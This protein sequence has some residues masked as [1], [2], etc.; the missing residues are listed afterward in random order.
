[1]YSCS[2]DADGAFDAIPRP[3]LFRKAI[4]H[5]EPNCWKLM[6]YWY[7]KLSV[8]VKWNSVVGKS[9]N[10]CKGTRQG[11]LTSRLLFNIFYSDLV[12]EL[13]NMEGGISIKNHNYNVFCYADDLLLTSTT[14]TGLQRLIDYSNEYITSH[15]LR[16]N[17]KKTNCLI[18]GKHQFI[19]EPLWTLN[20]ENLISTESIKYLGVTL[21]NKVNGEQ[22]VISRVAACRQA[23]YGLQGSGIYKFLQDARSISH[24]YRAALQP[25][26]TYGIHTVHLS[27]SNCKTLDRCQ[28]N[29]IKSAVGINT[30]SRT[31]ALLAAMK[32][33]RITQ[34]RDIQTLNLVKRIFQFP[35]GARQFYK[36]MYYERH[37]QKPNLVSRA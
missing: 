22:H 24:L 3:I 2:L 30:N 33:L 12:N 6:F 17:P 7:S 34:A 21:S 10:I 9:I 28:G 15:R 25:I 19:H 31:T 13:C 35:S 11:G 23:F 29:M 14:V 36:D 26:L 16:F 8:K 27:N 37:G 18:F 4:G 1:V 5:I 32:I 20:E